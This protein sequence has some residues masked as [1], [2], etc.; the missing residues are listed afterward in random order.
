MM[1]LEVNLPSL[2]SLYIQVSRNNSAIHKNILIYVMKKK[3]ILL[4][5]DVN[6]HSKGFEPLTSSLLTC[7]LPLSYE[8]EC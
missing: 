5:H 6:L 7:A 1:N 2:S 3:N 4:I 8:C